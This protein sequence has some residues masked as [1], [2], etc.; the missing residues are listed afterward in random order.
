MNQYLGLTL[1]IIGYDF[2]GKKTIANFLKQ[3][4]GL[5][6]LKVESIIQECFERVI[7]FEIL[8]KIKKHFKI[9]SLF[10]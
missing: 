7:F 2:S 1:S 5:E 8:Y 10:F 3:K 9:V 6:V 4:Y